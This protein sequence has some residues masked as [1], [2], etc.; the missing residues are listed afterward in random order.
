MAERKELIVTNEE[1]PSNSHKSKE[2]VKIEKRVSEKVVKGKVKKKK[3]S[4]GARMSESFLE[5]DSSN[6]FQYILWD[7]LI[8]AAKDTIFDVLTNAGRMFLYG[9]NKAPDRVRRDRG[10]SYVSYSSYYEED[11]RERPRRAV[12]RRA[13]QNFDDIFFDY[14]EDAEEVLDRLSDLVD[15]YQMASV[16]D[17]YDLVGMTSNY[18]DQKWGWYNLNTARVVRCRDG[19]ALRMPRTEELV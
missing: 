8:P 3:K 9:D 19:Y 18:T 14:R 17:L 11:R 16:G 2:E 10:K 1:F 12:N 5:D 13:S 4:L 7:V 15:E 6:V